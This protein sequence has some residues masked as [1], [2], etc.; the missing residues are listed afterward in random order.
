MNNNYSL[1][2]FDALSRVDAERLISASQQVQPDAAFVA[3]M[4]TKLKQVY[5]AKKEQPM[6]KIQFGFQFV[7]GVLFIGFAVLGINWLVS[8][9]AG[10]QQDSMT[11]EGT[12]FVC[13][14]TNG[15]G[16]LP[17]GESVE[18]P[19]YLG[20]GQLWTV[21]WPD[22]KVYVTDKDNR[23]ADGRYAMK[24]GWWRGT[25]GALSIEGRRLDA[26]SNPLESDIPE[27][28][29]ETGIQASALIF[30]EPGCWEVTGRV[31]SASLTFVT[32]VVLVD[33]FPW[34]VETPT[35]QPNR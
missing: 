20:N 32:E 6:Q 27:G 17:P 34:M 5:L 35:L 4:E 8:N 10:S 28:Y 12:A 2:D 1:D 23:Q 22:G 29:G 13:P 21:L 31:G 14:V 24:W 30:P 7:F 25:T 9:L 15:N 26:E 16:S 11:A 18:S 33:E 19:E 3:D